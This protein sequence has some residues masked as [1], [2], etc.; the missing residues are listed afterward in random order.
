MPPISLSLTR[1]PPMSPQPEHCPPHS[2][3]SVT[4]PEL[5]ELEKAGVHSI[6]L[7][8]VDLANIIR[9][10]VF[11]LSQFESILQAKP[12]GA[13]VTRAAPTLCFNTPAIPFSQVG[14]WLYAPDMT[15][16]KRLPYAPGYASVMGCFTGRG[17]TGSLQDVFHRA[18][19]LDPRAL[20]YE[21]VE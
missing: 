14:A 10:E 6:R 18:T 7:T 9:Y 4:V 8:W 3:S 2:P 13:P 19:G 12:P 1:A 15:T 21:A 16:L 17:S 5:V 20:L 11:P